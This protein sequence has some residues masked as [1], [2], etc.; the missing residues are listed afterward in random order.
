M[1]IF[2]TKPLEFRNDGPS[3]RQPARENRMLLNG[4]FLQTYKVVNFWVTDLRTSSVL[5]L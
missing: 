2:A 3:N 4:F 1:T 5:R